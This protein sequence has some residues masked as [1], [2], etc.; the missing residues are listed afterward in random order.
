MKS[1]QE[2]GRTVSFTPELAEQIAGSVEDFFPV[3]ERRARA[4]EDS[5]NGVIEITDDKSRSR[6]R[7]IVV[8]C[9]PGASADK[10]SISY[11]LEYMQSQIYR[12]LDA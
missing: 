5:I 2:R 4:T 8:R 1:F 6:G 7:L 12:E 9:I 3:L 10:E 11:A